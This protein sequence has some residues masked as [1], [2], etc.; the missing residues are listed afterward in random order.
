MTQKE[1][2]NNMENHIEIKKNGKITIFETHYV[3]HTLNEDGLLFPIYNGSYQTKELCFEAL[4]KESTM[5]GI[6]F[7]ILPVTEM[8]QKDL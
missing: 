4:A 8:S 1:K 6:N 7:I 3:I 2:H 5:M